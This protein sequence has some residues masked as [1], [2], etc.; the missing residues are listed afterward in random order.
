MTIA[1]SF[2]GH[3]K[4]EGFIMALFLLIGKVTFVEACFIK[5]DILFLTERHTR[6]DLLVI[7]NYG[8]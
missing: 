5:F 8:L 2:P 1:A 6:K 7:A 3:K 4:K